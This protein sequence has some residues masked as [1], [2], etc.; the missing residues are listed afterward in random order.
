MSSLLCFLVQGVLTTETAVLVHFKSIRSIFLV[1]L[2]VVI[3]LFAL[4]ACQCD[5]DSC[6]ISHVSAPPIIIWVLPHSFARIVQYLPRRK[7]DQ[8]LHC[9]FAILRA[10]KEP[11]YL[12]YK[13]F[14]TIIEACQVLFVSFLKKFIFYIFYLIISLDILPLV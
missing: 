13:H 6:F 2:C 3:T 10:K 12:R 11:L 4:S 1:F 9:L 8:A 7:E 14:S 5:F